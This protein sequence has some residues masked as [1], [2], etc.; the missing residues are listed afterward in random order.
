MWHLFKAYIAFLFRSTNQHGVHSPFVYDLITKCFYN[1]ENKNAYRIIS[2]YRKHMLS[3]DSKISVTD[4]GA[5]SRVFK[6]NKRKV[7]AI[8]RNAGTGPKRARLL[9]RLVGYLG[10]SDMLELGTS[11]GLGTVALAA[12]NTYKRIITIE[13]CPET[14]KI[15]ETGFKKL[16]LSGIELKNNTF[17]EVIPSLSG[18]FDLIYVDGNHQKEATLNYFEQL[19]QN[20]HNDTVMIFDD[21]HWSPG[22]EEAWNSIKEHPETTVSIDTFFWGFVFFRREQP[23]EHFVIRI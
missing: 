23:K 9:N 12:N 6:S 20:V 11:L 2:G 1:K 14:A 4:F 8:A 13:A 15:A 10:I 5:G 7:S 22:M 16:G 19:L 3:D 21:I 18:K 17:E